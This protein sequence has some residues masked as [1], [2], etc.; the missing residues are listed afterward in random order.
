MII[1]SSQIIKRLL[2]K[3]VTG[4]VM[5]DREFLA[6]KNCKRLDTKKVEFM[7]SQLL[8]P[9]MHLNIKCEVSHKIVCQVGDDSCQNGILAT[10]NRLMMVFQFSAD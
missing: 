9:G 1:T 7:S 10:F 5:R 6:S 3:K 4:N 8:P 2:N